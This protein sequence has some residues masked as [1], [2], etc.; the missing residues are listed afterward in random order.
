M[1]VCVCVCVWGTVHTE[2]AAVRDAVTAKYTAEITLLERQRHQEAQSKVHRLGV[3]GGGGGVDDALV[4]T[5]THTSAC[6]DRVELLQCGQC[7][8]VRYCSHDCQRDDWPTHKPVCVRRAP[9]T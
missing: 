8:A 9:P 6:Q 4:R 3:L 1:C 7:Q 2:A 5:L